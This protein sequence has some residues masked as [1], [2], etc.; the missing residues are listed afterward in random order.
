MGHIM[1]AELPQGEIVGWRTDEQSGSYLLIVSADGG[2]TI[3][4]HPKD[5]IIITCDSKGRADTRAF[6]TSD[7]R[8]IVGGEQVVYRL[9][10]PRIGGVV[11]DFL[12]A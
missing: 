12:I 11:W 4:T 5:R 10:D 7:R 6:L 2:Q 8:S 1:Y 9:K 3:K